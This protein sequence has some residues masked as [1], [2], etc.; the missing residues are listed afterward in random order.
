MNLQV[1][2]SIQHM[3]EWLSGREIRNLIHTWLVLSV[4]FPLE[5]SLLF[6]DFENPWC[7]FCTIMPEM[8][9]LCYLGK[10]RLEWLNNIV[11]HST[12]QN[13][14]CIV[15]NANG[16]LL[17]DLSGAPRISHRRGHQTQKSG[18]KP[19]IL[20]NFPSKLH[21]NYEKWSEG[22]RAWCRPYFHHW[23]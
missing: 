8:S 13:C 15:L 17:V 16:R 22:R 14:N 1:K 6:A 12:V 9:D 20:V 23:I 3:S 4:R 11:P 10:T 2:L 5:V 7:Q 21:E 19:I 18:R